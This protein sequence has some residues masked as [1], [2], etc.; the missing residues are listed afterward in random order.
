MTLLLPWDATYD[1]WAWIVWG[2]EVAHLN[3]HTADGPSWKPLPVLFTAPF[4]LAGHAAPA[5]WLIVA[6]A[7]GLLAFAAAYAAGRRLAGPIAGAVAGVALLLNLD[8][9]RVVWLGSSEGMLV[10]ALLAAVE[11]DAAGARRTAF[12]L[13][14]AC[15][16][17]RPEA[18]PFLALY[19]AWL[20]WRD[21]SS[22]PLVTGSAILVALLWLGPELWGSGQLWR[23]AD[24]AQQ[25]VAAAATFAPD[26]ALEV[27]RRADAMLLGPVPAAAVIAVA[28]AVGGIARRRR[29]A[30]TSVTVPAVALLALAWIGLVAVMTAHGFSG[31]SRYVMAPAALICVLAGVGGAQTAR[32]LAA[33]IRRARVAPTVTASL[34]AALI[35]AG[36]VPFAVHQARELGARLAV[37]EY[38]AEMRV[39]LERAVAA[40]GGPRAVLTCGQPVTE[41]YSVPMLAWYLGVHSASV[42]LDAP[43]RGAVFRARPGPRSRLDPPLGKGWHKDLRG[44]SGPFRV[45]ARCGRPIGYPRFTGRS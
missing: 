27:A 10:A 40:L 17:L 33:L 31:N 29:A 13:G 23:S 20:V 9:D 44:F 6:R 37:L 25:P 45:Y 14:V 35:A 38:Q 21:R 22:L 24:R 41:D 43:P 3:L 36:M 12:A 4:S 16:L 34:A 11:R 8:F 2:R 1:P 5:L 39:G 32:V 42:G 28:F 7:S 15:A 30:P 19:G 18:W 26:P